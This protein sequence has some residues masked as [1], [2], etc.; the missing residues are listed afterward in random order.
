MRVPNPPGLTPVEATR[1]AR[2]LALLSSDKSG[3]V[4]AAAA[5][6]TQFLRARDIDWRDLLVPSA[7]PARAAPPQFN[8]FDSWPQRWRAAVHVCLQAPADLVCGNDR[9]FLQTIARYEHRPSAKQLNWLARILTDVLPA[10]RAGGA[11]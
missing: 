5:A 11:V 6:A 8:L 1:L 7:L 2:I 9:R 3:E 10:A 4:G